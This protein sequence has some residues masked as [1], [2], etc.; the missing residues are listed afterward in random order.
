MAAGEKAVDVGLGVLTDI[1]RHG[2]NKL[3]FV[4]PVCIS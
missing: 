1:K 3:L 4:C 2:T